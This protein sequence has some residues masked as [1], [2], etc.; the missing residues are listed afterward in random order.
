MKALEL[1]PA[2]RFRDA[3]EM[4][5]AIE[6]TLGGPAVAAA[7]ERLRRLACGAD[8]AA[9]SRPRRPKAR[10]GRSPAR[11]LAIAAGAAALVA[12]AAAHT[13]FLGVLP[14]SIRAGFADPAPPSRETIPAVLGEPLPGVTMTPIDEPVPGPGDFRGPAPA[15]DPAAD[16]T[17]RGGT[18][19]GALDAPPPREIPDGDVSP[20]G[21]DTPSPEAE[22][23]AGAPEAPT[24]RE[25]PAAPATVPGAGASPEATAVSPAPSAA[26]ARPPRAAETGY[27]DIAVEPAASII[28]DGEPV[29]A[30]GRISM[31]EIAAGPHEIVC[32]REGYRDYVE[33]V[34]IAKGEL[35]R[36]RVVL[37][38]VAGS[39]LVES[40]PG[41]RLYVDGAYR[42]ALPL[43]RALPLA[44]G[45]HRIELRKPGYRSWS[46]DVHVPV[47][48]PLRIAIRLVPVS[49]GQ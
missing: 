6:E 4:A 46:T 44:P 35:S 18:D 9:R 8:D 49:D 1:D 28:I 13:G 7:R 33:T 48:E 12:I 38:E 11:A 27:I 45:A 22:I 23:P 36:R 37:A 40:D 30:S 5:R 20:P 39:L 17:A 15:G 3:A 2:K 10:R 42:G 16:S 34:R 19:D 32:R 43:A 24:P 47:E 14:Q 26:G 21:A 41:A 25:T 29:T 31:L